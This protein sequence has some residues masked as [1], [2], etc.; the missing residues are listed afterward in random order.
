M[1]HLLLHNIKFFTMEFNHLPHMKAG[2]LE[3]EW[4]VW[5]LELRRTLI[6]EI[7][8]N[9]FDSYLFLGL[10][11]LEIS[12]VPLETL[13]SGTF[14]GLKELQSLILKR[15]RLSSIEENVLA[16]IPFLNSLEIAICGPWKINSLANLFGTSKMKHLQSA[17]VEKCY[18]SDRIT[19]NTFSG[20]V[21]LQKFW[22][23]SNKIVEIAPHSFD[24]VLKTLQQLNLRSNKLRSLPKDLF[25]AGHFIV[26]DLTN[27]FLHCDCE[28]EKFRLFAQSA[29]YVQFIGLICS[30]P[31][32]YRGKNLAK[33]P[34]LCEKAS[35]GIPSIIVEDSAPNAHKLLGQM[36]NVYASNESMDF[37]FT[38]EPMESNKI[39]EYT[40]SINVSSH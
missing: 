27:N 31:D 37:Q 1:M 4:P 19:E 6:S 3:I 7:E 25:K 39:A 30:S 24:G 14:N 34:F 33:C 32:Q 10:K 8:E 15:L 11:H 35:F 5:K 17:I 36:N 16:P 29:V 23:I 40:F 18:W 28:M 26:I 2:W 21:S 20:L 9:A 38:A 22:L 12:V 13:K